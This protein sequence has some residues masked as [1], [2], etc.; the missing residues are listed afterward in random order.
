[1][2][3]IDLEKGVDMIFCN[4]DL[5]QLD[6]E[7]DPKMGD[8]D[9][10][11]LRPA[12]ME[13]DPDRYWELLRS[14]LR[15]AHFI[16]DDYVQPLSWQLACQWGAAQIVCEEQDVD[17]GYVHQTIGCP[18]FALSTLLTSDGFEISI[19]PRDGAKISGGYILGAGQTIPI[20]KMREHEKGF[21]VKERLSKGG[22][23]EL[24]PLPMHKEPW[25]AILRSGARTTFEVRY[26]A[27]EY[28][29]DF[30]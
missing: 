5:S 4:L 12:F 15:G 24:P 19:S 8:V 26:F 25:G 28:Q 17:L 18:G 11:N 9:L 10:R 14:K 6:F 29:V 3:A 2:T 30:G 16:S 20:L 21:D 22:S 13:M 23:P 7:E 1:M 27:G